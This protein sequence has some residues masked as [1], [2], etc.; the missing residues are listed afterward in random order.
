METRFY[1]FL[2]FQRMAHEILRISF[3]SAEDRSRSDSYLIQATQRL[4]DKLKFILVNF[5]EAISLTPD[6][7]DPDSC[8]DLADTAMLLI[9]R[10]ISV[11]R[12]N[13]RGQAV[14]RG[15]WNSQTM[16][17][18]EEIAIPWG[19]RRMNECWNITLGDRCDFCQGKTND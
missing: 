4:V 7:D 17:C 10:F 11:N 5:F 6:C 19:S 15:C 16:D 12:A 14:I 2:D 18:L 3:E 8:P 1:V 9:L 13:E